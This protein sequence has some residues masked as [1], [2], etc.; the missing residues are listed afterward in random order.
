MAHALV[1]SVCL[2]AGHRPVL[3]RAPLHVLAIGYFYSMLVALVSA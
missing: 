1:L 2:P 3:G